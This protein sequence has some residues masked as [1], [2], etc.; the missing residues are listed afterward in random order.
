MT[1]TNS[2][3]PKTTNKN[4]AYLDLD[5]QYVNPVLDRYF[6][7]V[8]ERG[9]GSYLYDLNGDRYLDFTCGIAVTAT[10]HCHPKV[11]EAIQKQAAQLMHTSVVTHHK[12]YID[13]AQKIAEIAPGRLNSVFF[14]NSGAEAVE[15]A[16][17]LARYITGR[18]A[19]I[20]FRGSFH[21]RTMMA[22]ALT[23]SKLYLK[24]L[25]EP[26]PGPIFTSVFPYPHRS[27]FKN[28][29]EACLND[30]ITYLE[31]IFH[32]LVHPKQVAA[33]IVEPI[34]GEGGYIVPPDGFLT[35]LR[36]I[37]DKHG[38]MLIFDEVQTGFGR[39]GKMFA[40]E[41]ELVEPDILLM[42]KG[43]ASGLPL[44]AFVCRSE[45][46]S[47]W[48]PGRHGSTFGGNPVACAASL[49]TIKVIE[50]GELLERSSRL[51]K[52][53]LERLQKFAVG[54]PHI[55]E[56]RGK[57]LMIGIEFDDPKGGP[58]TSV[59]KHVVEKCFEQKLL[60]LRC[61]SFNQVIRVIP[62]LNVSDAE[63]QKACEILEKSMTL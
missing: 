61:G 37:A 9:Q 46:S 2:K 24:E 49:A 16:L 3:D 58:G 63:A 47:K 54:K 25:Y 45:V 44:S 22:T 26:L 48:K 12:S 28:D 23:T 13:L 20:N 60:L 43:I 21:G 56:V 38:I 6:P 19:W 57:G 29:P 32:E 62:P 52:E 1:I 11:V 31:K 8:A 51:G 4:T 17:K 53:I 55:G 34:Q 7:I 36:K 27:P 39:T 59:A 50:E 30:S 41:H 42:A 5:K 18:P 10:G 35:H 33:M 15:G 14:A 40:C